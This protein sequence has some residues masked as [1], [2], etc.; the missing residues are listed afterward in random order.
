[1]LPEAFKKPA[2]FTAPESANRVIVGPDAN[3]SKTIVLAIGNSSYRSAVGA[4]RFGA[5]DARAFAAFWQAQETTSRKVNTRVLLDANKFQML[6]ELRLSLAEVDTESLQ[7]FYYSG[8]ALTLGDGTSLLLP[9][10]VE[11]NE[12][13]NH[14][15]EIGITTAE[16]RNLFSESRARTAILFIDATFPPLFSVR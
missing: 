10:D 6:S 2:Y 13:V 12:D 1:M 15:Y 5:T 7:I 9:I 3:Y 14:L 4:L 8:R 16:L 11:G